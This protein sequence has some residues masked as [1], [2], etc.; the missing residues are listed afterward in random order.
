MP[1]FDPSFPQ[2]DS[3][4]VSLPFRNQ[5]NALNDK[6]E[7][8]PAGPPG[9]AGEK[10][11]KGDPGD[12]G[13]AGNNGADGQ[14]GPVGEGGPEGPAGRSI[15][16]IRDNGDGRA[17]MDMS[18]GTTYGPY[19]I[20]SGPQGPPGP[21]GG[22]GPAGPS[23]GVGPEG[24]H[25]VNVRDP[26]DGRAMVDMTDGTSYGP[27]TVA[28]G[29]TGPGGPE[30][31]QG[32]AGEVTAQQLAQEISFAFGGTSA[33][34]NM[35][36]LLSLTVSDPPTQSELQAVANKMDELISALRR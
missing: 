25:V 9:P 16:S 6:I 3:E 15:V 10:G 14:P 19:I 32:P 22:E 30:G 28:S 8:V 36:Q 23:G 26:G 13:P 11:D 27:F 34:T 33:N 29:P 17:L 2:Q 20:A 35:V 18:D 1:T 5:F 24:R 7:T 31:P 4:L 12:A 21:N